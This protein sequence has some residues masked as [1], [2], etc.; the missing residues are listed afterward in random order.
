M[1]LGERAREMEQPGFR[2][3]SPDPHSHPPC[4]IHAAYFFS[5][6]FLKLHN[7]RKIIIQNY[8]NIINIKI[9]ITILNAVTL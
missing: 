8:I 3:P 1:E 7:I 9:K 6:N 5:D 4:T 2:A